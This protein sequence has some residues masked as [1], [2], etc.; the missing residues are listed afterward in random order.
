MNALCV[1]RCSLHLKIPSAMAHEVI[2]VTARSVPF[3]EGLPCPTVE[4]SVYGLFHID[5]PCDVECLT[6]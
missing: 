3:T 2:F 1:R 5:V 4:F 6:R